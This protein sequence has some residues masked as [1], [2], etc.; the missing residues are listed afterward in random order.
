MDQQGIGD[1][2]AHGHQGVEAGQ[3][4]LEHHLDAPAGPPQGPAPQAQQVDALEPYGASPHRCQAD[5]GAA[6][7]AFAAAGGAHQ[8]DR[9]A[10]VELQAD[11]ING[12]EPALLPG[13]G[14]EG[15][16]AAQFCELE[17][18]GRLAGGRGGL[19]LPGPGRRHQALGQGGV[20]RREQLPGGG[21]LH[22]P[23]LVEHGDALAPA[24]GQGQVVADQ[25]Q[26]AAAVL[27]KGRQF[28]H[29]L[30]GHGHIQAGGGFIGN[31]Q[32][33]LQGHRQGDRQPLAHAT[34]E[35]MGVTVV[36]IGANADPGQQGL[37]PLP[38]RPALAQMP[39][40]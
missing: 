5:Q 11:A 30:A 3:G 8:A 34:T 21:L 32:G 13:Q 36:A 19:A 33:R 25:Q 35:F 28:G 9:F 15:M 37:G 26:G 17:Q 24:A 40:A 6:E 27:T 1:G 2:F 12:L 22:Q 29:H 23:A 14:G 20:G 4:V 38:D 16:P 18:Q 39:L 10:F 31:H 7:G